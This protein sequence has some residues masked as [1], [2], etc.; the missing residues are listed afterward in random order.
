V[1]GFMFKG[2]SI[3]PALGFVFCKN[4]FLVEVIFF[5]ASILPAHF[6]VMQQSRLKLSKF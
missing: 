3:T 1:G 5:Q 6:L 4:N 2:S